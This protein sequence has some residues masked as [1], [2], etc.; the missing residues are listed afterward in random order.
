MLCPIHCGRLLFAVCCIPAVMPVQCLHA[1]Q[2]EAG[3]KPREVKQLAPGVLAS[4]EPLFTTD[5]LPRYRVVVRDLMLG[6][7]LEAPKVPL[8]GFTLMEL[9]AGAVEV[10]VN[11]KVTRYETDSYWLVPNGARVAIRN[12]GELSVIRAVTLIPR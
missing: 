5:S 6:P 4:A 8:E 2:Q 9:R 7:K 12:V 10:S 11:G 1:Q 3:H